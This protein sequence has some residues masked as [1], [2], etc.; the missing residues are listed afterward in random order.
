[1]GAAL[2]ISNNNP[3]AIVTL[4]G[5]GVEFSW[6]MGDYIKSEQERLKLNVFR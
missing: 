6:R 1:M 2:P 3:V 4:W 5:F